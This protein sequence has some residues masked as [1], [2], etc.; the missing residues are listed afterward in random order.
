MAN[1]QDMTTRETLLW[2]TFLFPVA[3]VA[4][5]M[6]E[7]FAVDTS[8][9]PLTHAALA[10]ADGAVATTNPPSLIWR[11]DGTAAHYIVEFATTRD[12]SRDLIRTGP[13]MLPFYN[14]NQVLADGTWY[15]RY[16]VVR[17]GG[18]VSAPGP[19]RSFRIT[20][21]S[22]PLPIP[23]P[24]E[25]LAALPAHPRIYVRPEELAAFQAR[26]LG[27]GRTAWANI[28]MKADALLALTPTRP[29]LQ[30]L[31]AKLPS[32]RQQVFWV[33][34]GTPWVPVDYGRAELRR[35]AERAD[36]LSLAYQISGEKRYAEGARAWAMF[37]APFRMDYHLRTVA[38][39]GQHDTVVYSY[40]KGLQ[41]MAITYDRLYALLTPDERQALLYH[42]EYHGEAALH[43]IRDVMEIHLD[44][45]SSHSQQCMHALLPTALAIAGDSAKAN[46]WLAY[47]VPQYA[48]RIAWTSD[49]GGYFEGQGYAFKFTYILDGLC[50]LRSATGIDLF[51]KPAIHNTGDFW[52]YCMSLNYWWPHW[53]DNMPLVNP[54]GNAGDAYI[55]AMMAS[56]TGNR[57]LQWWSETVP[58]DP[59]A[60]PFSYLSGTGLKPL[61]PIAVAQAKVF[62]DTGV[63]AAFDRFYDHGAARIFF[64]SSK[65][66]GH[67]HAQAD[68]NSFVLHAGG[69]ILAADV[70]YY[71]YYGDD[72]YEN[73]S[74]QTIAHNSILIDGKGQTNDLAGR[75]AITGFFNSPQYVYFAGD[76]SAAYGKAVNRFRRDVV[77]LRPDVFIIADELR[78]DQPGRW[79][80]L[81]N[82]FTAP[83]IDAAKQEFT[84]TQRHERLWG[85]HVFPESL[86]Y[87]SSNERK[88]PLLSRRW[89][90]YGEVFPEPW[91][92]QAVTGKTGET[93][94]LT[95]LHAYDDRDGRRV[96]V[97]DSLRNA[98]TLGVRLGGQGMTEDLLLRRIQDSTEP[99]S[100]WKARTDGRVLAVR[101]DEAGSI[102]AW[103]A[104]TAREAAADGTTLL[105]ASAPV[106]IAV[107]RSAAAAVQVAVQATQPTQLAVALPSRPE[108]IQEF[109][110]NRFT[111][112]RDVAFAWKDGV[113]RFPVPEGESV[114]WADPVVAPTALPEKITLTLSG[115]TGDQVVA[116]ETAIAENGDWIAYAAVEPHAPGIYE[117]R[118]STPGTEFLLQD[119]WDPERSTRGRDRLSGLICAG[120]QVVVRFP[121]TLNPPAISG[122]LAQAR[123]AATINLL[124]NGDCEAGLPHYP[125]RAWT[126]RHGMMG[127]PATAG[128]KGFPEWSTE[129]AASGQACLKFTRPINVIGEWRAPYNEVARDTLTACAPPVRLVH[130]G[131]YVLTWK[132]KG[133][134]THVRMVLRDGL[135]REIVQDLAPSSQWRD[136]R[137][138]ADLPAGHTEVRFQYRAGGADDQVLWVDDV[139]LAPAEPRPG[140]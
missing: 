96:T 56:A 37:V 62:P 86:D 83:V 138:E 82:T 33:E 89:T 134:A 81:L 126:V 57:P 127:E 119:R 61:P 73:V 78:A 31:P 50:A 120:T 51:R 88:F 136:Y 22:V 10:P 128:T 106:S 68:Q 98:T 55:S 60:I 117:M 71:S 74:A 112:G 44:Y 111:A 36:L 6:D 100:G 65:W 79:S 92:M 8:P 28:Q 101:R 91:R 46:D 7:T 64:R 35:D 16:F 99:L 113:A 39:R 137:I 63:V 38:E 58:A 42:V 124:R 25:I 108:R 49:D 17:P 133:T 135:G 67:S 19:V 20:A 52:L 48:N 23:S 40:E 72:N 9:A 140:H 109:A 14:H 130:D 53:G 102:P 34:G 2:L 66:G 87:S 139:V 29:A 54:Y 107:T 12:F 123:S 114:F 85:R 116:L 121:P 13:V 110:P 115:A 93:S 76:A 59:S 84:V 125:P 104:V 15:W 105:A 3:V 118:S 1:R 90:R 80:W 27:E 131:A 21:A 24:A 43:W 30:P 26:R 18:A 4:T 70:G 122:R 94:Y 77:Y 132:V 103:M 95:V 41:A 97:T 129:D 45:Q 11:H 32:H 69:E 5:A 75:G 47:V